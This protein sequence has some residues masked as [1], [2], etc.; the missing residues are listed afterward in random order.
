MDTDT[1][2]SC[3]WRLTASNGRV[4]AVSARPYADYGECRAGLEQL[5]ADIEELQGEL[6]HSSDGAGWAWRLR[7]RS[8]GVVAVSRGPMSGI[9]R[10]RRRTT[11]SG[12]S[13]PKWDRDGRPCGT[14]Q[15]AAGSLRVRHRK[16]PLG[17]SR[18]HSCGGGVQPAPEASWHVTMRISERPE[19]PVPSLRDVCTRTRA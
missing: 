11:G 7:D 10:A 18:S 19:G 13:S 17:G 16:L 14:T 2:G 8:G 3:S 6:H 12:C 15:S 9:R 5:C 1:D 4:I